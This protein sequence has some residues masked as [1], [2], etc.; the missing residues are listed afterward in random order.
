MR[1]AMSRRRRN[2]IV[3]V[4]VLLLIAVV[5]LDHSFGLKSA[6]PL[7]AEQIKSKDLTKYQNKTFRVTRILDGDTLEI[8]EPDKK[9]DS[10]RIRLLGIDTPETK[11]ERI[12][13]MYFGPEAT[14]FAENSALNKNIT[15]LLDNIGHTRDKYDRLLAYI[16]LDDDRILNEVLIIEGFAYADLRFE[17]SFYERYSQLETTARRNKKGLWKEVKRTQLPEWL[18]QMKPKLLKN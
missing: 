2:T 18:Q 1:Y 16:K 12:S 6:L 10:T 7:S 4:S 17:H 14:Q 3:S 15:V 9:F 13:T 5:W 11:D 8:N